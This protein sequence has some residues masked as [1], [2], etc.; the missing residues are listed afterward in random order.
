MSSSSAINVYIFTVHICNPRLQMSLCLCQASRILGLVSHVSCTIW[1]WSLVYRSS[2]N[3]AWYYNCTYCWLH[4][5]A[6]STICLN[7]SY[8]QDN[9]FVMWHFAPS[10]LLFFDT[11]TF[12]LTTVQLAMFCFSV[13]QVLMEFHLRLRG[14][15][16]SW[17]WRY[18]NSIAGNLNLLSEAEHV[19]TPFRS[20]KPV[21]HD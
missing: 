10:C 9:I 4:I 3:L 5:F 20:M 6:F 11:N 19:Q 16:V 7:T 2:G 18:K 1:P 17:F 13:F 15:I 14:G 21:P 8:L 12:N